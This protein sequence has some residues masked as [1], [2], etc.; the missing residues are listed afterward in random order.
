MRFM[1]RIS[2]LFSKAAKHGLVSF[3]PIERCLEFFKYR[4]GADINLKTLDEGVHSSVA[5]SHVLGS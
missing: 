3:Q 2:L 5:D 4:C 1:S